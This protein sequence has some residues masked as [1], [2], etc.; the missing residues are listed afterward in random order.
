MLLNL[1]PRINKKLIKSLLFYLCINVQVSY[2]V[3]V[4]NLVNPVS[5]YV[6]HEQELKKIKERLVLLKKYL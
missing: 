3:D 6:N 1:W 2:A 4:T 5:Y